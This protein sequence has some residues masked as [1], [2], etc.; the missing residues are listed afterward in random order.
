VFLNASSE[1]DNVTL[2]DKVAITLTDKAPI[3]KAIVFHDY[4]HDSGRLPDIHVTPTIYHSVNV[5]GSTIVTKLIVSVLK[6]INQL[7]LSVNLTADSTD[8]FTHSYTSVNLMR[9]IYPKVRLFDIDKI[10]NL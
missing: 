7:Y 8:I 5:V 10:T 6:D 2:A 3:L 1:V 9:I 4:S